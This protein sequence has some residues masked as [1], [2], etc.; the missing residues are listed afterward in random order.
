[1]SDVIGVN[2]SAVGIRNDVNALAKGQN[3]AEKLR[4]AASSAAAFNPEDA[5][6]ASG[7]TMTVTTTYDTALS[8]NYFPV[9]NAANFEFTGARA[10]AAYSDQIVFPVS[11]QFPATG[12][13]L[14]GIGSSPCPSDYAAWGWEIQF[15]TQAAKIQIKLGM[16]STSGTY[17]I[18]I[19]VDGQFVSKTG[20]VA[21]AGGGAANYYTLDFA[22]VRKPRN[23]VVL[24]TGQV[25]FSSAH[26]DPTSNIA[27]TS[28]AN[29]VL[30]LA[31]G[32]SYSEGQGAT[33]VGQGSWVKKM[34]RHL[35]WWDV[36]QVAVGGT[37]YLNAGI[38]RSKIGDQIGRWLTVNSDITGAQVDAVTVFAGYNDYTITPLTTFQA[39]ALADFIA[40][41]ALC[42]NAMIIV[43]GAWNGRRNS[44]ALTLEI[45]GYIAA[46]FAQFADDNSMF[47]PVSSGVAPWTFGTG[48]VASPANNG[49]ADTD[50]STDSVHPSDAGH[51]TLARRAAWAIRDALFALR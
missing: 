46:A 24:G 19:M 6:V 30:A 37:G 8:K 28:S 15:G 48:R 26:V 34:G 4:R 9:T 3:A 18:L 23:I 45:E 17:G 36:R 51:E 12:G 42:P 49:N 47:I 39:E 31:T 33:I 11:S 38:G 32:D 25:V 20:L 43:G 21:A 40:I 16:P 41:R 2:K 5:P 13:N 29:K 35:G 44:D 1:M 27:P 10:Y 22:G 7:V 50:V 14:A